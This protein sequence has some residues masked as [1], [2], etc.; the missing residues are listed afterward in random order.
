M[1]VTIK[2][3]RV[4]AGLTQAEAGELSGIGREAIHAIELG[5]R[6]IKV[7]EMDVLCA[8]Y[9]CT[10]DDII[11]PHKLTKSDTKE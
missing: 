4:N 9:K 10:Q 6:Y 5:K 7:G 11:L 8:I 2:A 1:K 3:A